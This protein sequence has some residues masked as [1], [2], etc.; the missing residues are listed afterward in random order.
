[1]ATYE[2]NGE[3]IDIQPSDVVKCRVIAKG[4]DGVELREPAPQGEPPKFIDLAGKF[5]QSNCP[6]WVEIEEVFEAKK[7]LVEQIVVGAKKGRAK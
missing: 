6:S 4:Y 2:V 3:K 5:F 1:M 7:E